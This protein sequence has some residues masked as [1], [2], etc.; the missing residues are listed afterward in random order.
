VVV[1]A[2]AGLDPTVGL[3]GPGSRPVTEWLASGLVALLETVVVTRAG[4]GHERGDGDLG[5]D[6]VGGE[7][8]VTVTKLTGHDTSSPF[9]PELVQL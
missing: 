2:L 6:L 7:P 5:L 1:T 4:A 3:A 8:D 9:S